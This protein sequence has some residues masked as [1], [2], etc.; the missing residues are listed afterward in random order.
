MQ[1][2]NVSMQTNCGAA[3]SV[4]ASAEPAP[5]ET[6]S[7]EGASSRLGLLIGGVYRQWRRQA[8]LSCKNHGLTDASRVP[9]LVLYGAQAPMRQKELAQALYLDTSSLVRVLDQLRARGLLDWTADP[10]DRRAK[11]IALTP[12]GRSTAADILSDSLE[13]ER[14]ILA[15]LSED[16]AR[17]LRQALE[18]ISRRFDTL[19]A[20]AVPSVCAASGAGSAESAA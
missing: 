18:K 19:A 17:I 8:D 1:L 20:A 9:L 16:E 12:E 6:S 2:H 3:P 10:D 7:P 4:G 11:C 5:P 13:V 15:D 14:Q